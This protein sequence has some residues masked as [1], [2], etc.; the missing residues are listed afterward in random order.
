M[1]Q[2]E[3]DTI[4]QILL[5]LAMQAIPAH[6]LTVLLYDWHFTLHIFLRQN[7]MLELEF[8]WLFISST[9]GFLHLQLFYTAPKLIKEQFKCQEIY[10]QCL[11]LF[12]SKLTPFFLPY[13]SLP[14]SI[15]PLRHHTNDLWDRLGSDQVWVQTCVT[16]SADVAGD[17]PNF[18]E[19]G[20][21]SNPCVLRHLL[22]VSAQN[23]AI[24][25]VSQ[26][27]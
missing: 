15:I 19:S 20:K 9:W 18:H 1:N 3:N 5:S 14:S 21:T 4:W 27:I 7:P 22:F 24:M 26:L 17:C 12:K 6:P 23:I 11:F 10:R 2:S 8:Y 13:V 25:K 16:L